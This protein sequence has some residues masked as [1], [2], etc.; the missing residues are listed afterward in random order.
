MPNI[1]TEIEHL[2]ISSPDRNNHPPGSIVGSGTIA[3][4]PQADNF[5]STTIP[6]PAPNTNTNTNTL[7]T[8]QPP[9]EW[10]WEGE[11]PQP[12][13]QNTTPSSSSSRSQLLAAS[14]HSPP[15]SST[16]P[17]LSLTQGFEKYWEDISDEEITTN[18]C[19]QKQRAQN[20]RES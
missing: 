4:Q 19:K 6:A 7:P 10:I 13:S 1:T 12:P 14:D 20:M 11:L 2:S 8:P 17:T 3:Q 9:S 15:T 16:A 5:E 18:V